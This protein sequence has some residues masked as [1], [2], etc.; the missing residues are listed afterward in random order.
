MS[1]IIGRVLRASTQGFTFGCRVSALKEWQFGGLVKAEAS[2]NESIFG[3]IYNID[4]NDDPLVQRM[5]L[6]DNLSQSAIED[7]R[8]NRML[9]VE[10]SVLAVGY[11]HDDDI[12]HGLP[13]RPPLNLDPV[14]PIP[15]DDVRPFSDKMGYLRIVMNSAE[16]GIPVDQLLV[17]HIRQLY[18]L[19]N[20]DNQWASNVIEEVIELLRNSYE[21]LVPTLEALSSALQGLEPPQRD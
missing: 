10:V 16:S 12:L 2:E 13:P 14:R 20:N 4:I 1:Q 8:R 19:R 3:L 15:L 9:P 6:S 17:A 7:Q 21:T 5:V 18:E 11:E